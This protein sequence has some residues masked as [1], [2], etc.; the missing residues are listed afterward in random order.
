VEHIS[1][2]E[3][4]PKRTV[5]L[6]HDITFADRQSLVSL[7]REY[8]DVF[9]FGPE[10]MHGIVPSVMKRR[11]NVDPRHKPVIQKE[12]YMGQVRA[13]TANTEVQK[14]L[15]DGFI[16]ECQYPEWI[17]NVVSVKKPNGTWRMCMNFMDLNKTCPKDSYPG[18]R[19]TS[20]W[21]PWPVTPY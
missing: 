14:F 15:K 9:A 8:K 5:R 16:R 2:E 13:A 19:S 21:M 1:L 10:E 4:R 3:G 20:W 7:L 11:L 17:S 12:C 18:Q 6:G